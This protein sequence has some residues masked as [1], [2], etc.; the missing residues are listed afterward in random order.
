[1]A[2][3]GDDDEVV[4][5]DGFLNHISHGYWLANSADKYVQLPIAQAGKQ[6]GIRTFNHVDPCGR[7]NVRKTR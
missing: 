7:I 5:E 3:A 1:M 6:I 4:V 2:G